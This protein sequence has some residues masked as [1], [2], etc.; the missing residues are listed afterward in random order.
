MPLPSTSGQY[1]RL[2]GI[3]GLGYVA[4][5][6][7]ENMA[8]LEAPTVGSPIEAIRS[9]YADATLMAVCSTAGALALLSYCV[10]AVA[11]YLHVRGADGSGHPWA[12]VGLVGGIAGPVV[13]A[14]GLTA[15]SVLA[16]RATA[17]SDDVTSALF[18]LSLHARIVSGIFVAMFLAGFGIAALRTTRLPRPVAWIA[19]ALAVPMAL[20]PLAAFTAGGELRL[21]VT[22]AFACQ[23]LWIFAVSLW[24]AL[25]ERASVAVFARRS[26]FLLLVLAAGL[27]GL[28]LLAAPG[29]TGQF[30][31]WGLGPEPLAA[32]AGGA[33][34]GS[35]AVYAVALMRPWHEV[36]G[37]VAGAVVL[38]VSVLVITLSHLGQF[39]LDRLQAWAWV[40]LFAGF[41]AGTLGLL[42]VGG[43]GEPASRSAPIAGSARA[44][45][46]GV[47]AVLAA[48]ALV[49]WVDPAVL[50]GPSPF[51]LPPLG[52]RFA[53]S[54]IALLAVLAG[55]AAWTNRAVE[56]RLAGLALVLL[57]VGMLAAALRTIDGLDG[58]WPGYAA[59]LVVL[60]IVGAQVRVRAARRA[61]MRVTARHGRLVG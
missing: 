45:L 60:A 29:A 19:C 7:I 20:A 18:E 5:V 9:L 15:S 14:V 39:D 31:A 41:S 8:I 28:G 56:A 36:R 17:L 37:L 42:A 40:V 2:A 25:G 24:L 3:A 59:A 51:E 16:A 12:L 27:V 61:S 46:G 13:A 47:A 26:A 52:G 55:S 58:A 38:S 4:G 32:F 33:Y 57:P 21:A 22:I 53:G 10:L 11:L 30:F 50:A 48:L 6:A 43:R 54:W 1:R 35:A 34:V 49:L 44:V 23:S